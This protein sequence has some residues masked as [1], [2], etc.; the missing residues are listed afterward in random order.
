VIKGL[1]NELLIPIVA[2]GTRDAFHALRTDEQLANRFRPV[3]LPKWKF[4]ID[5]LRFL[6]TYESLLPLR[7]ESNLSNEAIAMKILGMA[8]GIIGE[9]ADLLRMASTEAIHS[10]EECISAALLDRIN[11]TRASERTQIEISKL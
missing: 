9:L 8:G 5:Y 6:S 4:D 10:K 7:N 11:W 2:V 1:G 3:A